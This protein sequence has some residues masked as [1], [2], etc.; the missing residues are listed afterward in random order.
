MNTTS[1]GSSPGA[2]SW[3]ELLESP[4]GSST[5]VTPLSNRAR[6]AALKREGYA[7]SELPSTT[8]AVVQ[9]ANVS[10]QSDTLVPASTAAL[11]VKNDLPS[12]Q[13]RLT[14]FGKPA[15][16]ILPSS[17]SSCRPHQAAVR[18]GSQI[19]DGRTPPVSLPADVQPP[20]GVWG[21]AA[22]MQDI[23]EPHAVQAS[24]NSTSSQRD[25]SKA[26]APPVVCDAASSTAAE[27]M[28]RQKA[29]LAVL[30]K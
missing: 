27:K 2:P 9:A 4:S 12:E 7:A 11:F 26:V 16:D 20:E 25:S 19:Q 22:I 21:P 18:D 15:I 6:R 10:H 29:M 23:N 28:R 30:F 24:R 8:Q 13:L 5:T 1:A 3:T 17:P 14:A